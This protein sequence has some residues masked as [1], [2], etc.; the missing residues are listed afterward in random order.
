MHFR[1]SRRATIRVGAVEARAL[2]VS[3]VGELGWELHVAMTDLPVLH[4][5]LCAAGRAGGSQALRRLRDELDAPG[6]GLSR[7]G[8]RPHHR[9]HPDRGGP[10]PP[11]AHRRAGCSRAATRCSPVPRRRNA[12]AHG[13]ALDGAGRRGRSVLHVHTV[14]NGGRARRHRDLRLRPDTAPA[15]CS[16][17]RT[18]VRKRLRPTHAAPAADWRFRSSAA[19]VAPG[20]STHHPTIRPT[21]DCEAPRG[22]LNDFPEAT[23]TEISTPRTRPAFETIDPGW[24]CRQSRLT[25]GGSHGYPP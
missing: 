7:V 18:C 11:R 24:A 17:S 10:R 23:W 9:A 16:R 14:W 3:Y 4:E 1:G 19:G 21:N 12:L 8:R 6:E 15:R 20:C 5:A 22:R 2:R 25:Q 13:A